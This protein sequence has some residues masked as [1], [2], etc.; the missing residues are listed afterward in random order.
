MI[1]TLNAERAHMKETMSFSK[2]KQ[3]IDSNKVEQ[4]RNENQ[5]LETK[6]RFIESRL[7]EVTESNDLSKK[8]LEQQRDWYQQGQML[9]KSLKTLA[10]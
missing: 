8:E 10:D 4:L 5:E 1:N 9:M 6:L 7:M 3:G 2:Q